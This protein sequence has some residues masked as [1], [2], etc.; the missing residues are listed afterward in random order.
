MSIDTEN[1][2]PEHV[3]RAN[4]RLIFGGAMIGAVFFI[5]ALAWLVLIGPPSSHKEAGQGQPQQQAA[6]Q[7]QAPAQQAPGQ[8]QTSGQAPAQQQGQQ[9]QQRPGGQQQA[10]ARPQ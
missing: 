7:Q 2:D 4:G 3:Q 10:P 5:A 1:H 6:T 8:P 9:P